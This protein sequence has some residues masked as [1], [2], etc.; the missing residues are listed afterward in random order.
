MTQLMITAEPELA[1]LKDVMYGQY[2]EDVLNSLYKICYEL[3]A[4]PLIGVLGD[5][6]QEIQYYRGLHD[7]TTR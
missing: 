6:I 2:N 3:P 5:A 7:N 1:K 4:C